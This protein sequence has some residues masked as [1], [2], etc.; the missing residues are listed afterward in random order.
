MI[1]ALALLLFAA[2]ASEDA[3][4]GVGGADG[5]GTWLGSM[6]WLQH[7]DMNTDPIFCGANGCNSYKDCSRANNDGLLEGDKDAGDLQGCPKHWVTKHAATC[8]RNNW[9]GTR[10]YLRECTN[11]RWT[12]PTGEGK[13][14]GT[15]A[16]TC[17]SY[18][19]DTWVDIGYACSTAKG[20]GCDCSG[21]ACAAPAKK[22]EA[23]VG[24]ESHAVAQQSGSSSPTFITVTH[25]FAAVGLSALLYGSFR[26]YLGKN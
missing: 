15:C 7:P 18:S 16:A 23:E 26:H 13:P 11:P 8:G 14:S 5:T 2:C 19:C 12:K 22:S 10:Q 6:M 20:W 3:E 25:V 1:V 24:A 9:L 21:C 4:M 17:Y